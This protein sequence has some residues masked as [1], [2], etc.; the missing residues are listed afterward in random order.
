MEQTGSSHV[1]GLA[2]LA[3]GSASGQRAVRALAVEPQARNLDIVVPLK[4]GNGTLDPVTFQIRKGHSD[5]LKLICLPP[6]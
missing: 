3:P 1:A 5:K 4:P 2:V 6:P